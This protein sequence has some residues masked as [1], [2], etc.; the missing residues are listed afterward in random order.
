[1]NGSTVKSEPSTEIKEE[2]K[3]ENP[4]E[5]N[6]MKNH[7][8]PPSNK[9]TN[10]ETENNNQKGEM[11]ANVKQ[12]SSG[13]EHA[14]TSVVITTA[15]CVI[16]QGASVSSS[17]KTVMS[18]TTSMAHSMASDSHFL[19]QQSQIFVFSTRMANDAAELVM[20]GKYKNILNF[21]TDQPE[22]QN[23]LQKNNIKITPDTK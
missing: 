17:S 2:I 4:P 16:T 14:A 5:Q 13:Q 12:E 3:E 19:Q 20:A 8:G 21:H 9:L 10:G 7:T 1:M 22:T 11:S 18:N 15:D 23:F 6:L